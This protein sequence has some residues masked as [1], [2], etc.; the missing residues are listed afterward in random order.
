MTD[1]K[2]LKDEIR[3]LR[4]ELAAEREQVKQLWK[5]FDRQRAQQF[6]GYPGYD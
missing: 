3:A 4:K 6:A 2:K 5:L 1:V